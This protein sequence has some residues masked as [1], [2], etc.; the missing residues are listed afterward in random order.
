MA[1][2][3]Y[4]YYDTCRF[5]MVKSLTTEQTHRRLTLVICQEAVI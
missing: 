3:A 1:H 5:W 2:G 4:F